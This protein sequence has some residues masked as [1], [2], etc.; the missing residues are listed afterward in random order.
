MSSFSEKIKQIFI[1]INE[2]ENDM[3]KIHELFKKNKFQVTKK[4]GTG[5]RYDLLLDKII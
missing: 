1:E 2:L 5:S 4:I 3:S